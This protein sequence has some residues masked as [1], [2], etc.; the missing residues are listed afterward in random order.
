VSNE[1]VPFISEDD[2]EIYHGIFLVPANWTT[3]GTVIHV[4]GGH[5]LEGGQPI[6]L[7]TTRTMLSLCTPDGPIV[8]MPLVSIR[9]V[10]VVDLTGM[11]IPIRTPSGIVEMVP[12]RAKGIAIKYELNE[13]GTQIEL[14]LFT[15]ASRSAFDWVNVIQ[16]AIYSASSDVG[17]T[18]KINRR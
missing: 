16:Q 5:G 7:A 9:A 15:L 14:T 12:A 13:R 11:A 10:Q 4:A 17:N 1:L 2:V 8:S 3:R 18:G 6:A